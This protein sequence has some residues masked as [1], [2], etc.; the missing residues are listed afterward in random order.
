MAAEGAGARSSGEKT[1]QVAR[2][3]MQAHPLGEPRRDIGQIGFDRG[4]TDLFGR[5]LQATLVGVADS[6][7]AAAVLVMGEGAEGVPAAI[8]RGAERFVGEADGPGAVAGLRP[9]KEDLFR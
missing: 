5:T 4:E 2:H 9:L 7:A 1:E 3:L 8:V 6:L